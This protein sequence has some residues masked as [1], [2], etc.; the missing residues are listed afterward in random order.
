MTAG[1][2]TSTGAGGSTGSGP[3]PQ[4]RQSV[5]GD[6][7]AP[8]A[9][10]TPPTTSVVNRLLG[11]KHVLTLRSWLTLLDDHC[12]YQGRCGAGRKGV[13]TFERPSR[14]RMRVTLQLVEN[15]RGVHPYFASCTTG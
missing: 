12:L 14:A 11:V 6:I 4:R 13:A 5:I 9:S 10:A 8:L 2:P 15:D 7:F 3:A 1:A